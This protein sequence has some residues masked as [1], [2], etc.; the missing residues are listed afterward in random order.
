MKESQDGYKTALKGAS[1]FGGMQIMVLLITMLKYKFI[2]ILL[3][4]L[5]FGVLSIYN[6][7]LTFVSTITGLG[8]NNSAIRDIACTNVN[9]DK[10]Q[11]IQIVTAISRWILCTSI[12]GGIVTVCLSS[13]LSQLMFNNHDYTL[14][15]CILSIGLFFA[16]MYKWYLAILQGMQ[17]RLKLAKANIYGALGGLIFSIPILYFFRERGIVVSIVVS[18]FILLLISYTLIRKDFSNVIQQ[19]YKESFLLGLNTVK[20]GIML[21]LSTISIS[22]LEIVIKAFIANLDTINTVGLFQAG[23]SI[24]ITYLGVVFTAIATDYYPRLS[25]CIARK[26]NY[27][28]MVNQQAEIALLCLAPLISIMTLFL[29]FFVKILYSD[30]F[31]DIVGMTRLL[32]IGSIIKAG[33][34]AISYLY[35]SMNDG[36]IFL[37]NELGIKCLSV[38]L[39][40]VLFYYY[41]LIGI[42]IAYIIIYIVYFFLV[43]LVAYNKYQ[44]KYTS[45]FWSVFGGVFLGIIVLSLMCSVGFIPAGVSMIYCAVFL[46]IDIYL[47]NKRVNILSF[48]KK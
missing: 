18:N 44:F 34:W 13:W 43:M 45:N 6:S 2:A 35:L 9:S 15:F 22:L 37:F 33:S 27:V 21:S 23:W 29:P 46:I 17:Q 11:L 3:G 31:I 32:L 8:L 14:G 7:A 30:S 41:G 36:R 38:P 5:G 28:A 25:E 4:P 24:N 16:G 19:S 39:Y 40:L 26:N 47:I 10:K 48:F 42:G 12:L 1:F 20:L